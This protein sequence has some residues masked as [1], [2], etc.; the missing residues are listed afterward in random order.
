MSNWDKP[1]IYIEDGRLSPDN[2][3]VENAI[4]HYVVGRK[5]WLFSGSQ[6]GAV[7]SATFFSL[8]ETANANDLELYA[9]LQHIFEKLPLAQTE[10]DLQNLLPPKLA[11]ESIAVGD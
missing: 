11:P 5:N 8:I 9:Y 2:N 1:I 4:R 3:L 6:D 10:Q 7:A